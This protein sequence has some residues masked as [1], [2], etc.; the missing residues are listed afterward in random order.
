MGKVLGTDSTRN[1]ELEANQR[2]DFKLGMGDGIDYK[3]IDMRRSPL[4]TLDHMIEQKL[5]EAAPEGYIWMGKTDINDDGKEV[6]KF[7]KIPSAQDDIKARTSTALDGLLTELE[8]VNGSPIDKPKLKRLMLSLHPHIRE[9]LYEGLTEVIDNAYGA[10]LAQQYKDV[11]KEQ[12]EK[13]KIAPKYTKL[14]ST[15]RLQTALA[16]QFV[17]STA[18]QTL[19]IPLGFV[20]DL[21]KEI[22][23]SYGAKGQWDF[24]TQFTV[25]LMT[26]IS[27]ILKVPDKVVTEQLHTEVK[28]LT[29]AGFQF[30]KST[31]GTLNKILKDAKSKLN[32]KHENI[33]NPEEKV[34]NAA[35]AAQN[36]EYE[37]AMVNNRSLTGDSKDHKVFEG[38]PTQQQGPSLGG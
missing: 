6:Q 30:D 17:V 2:E 36:A 28:K 9:E 20:K 11:T 10:E 38:Q 35:E 29:E 19:D 1:T 4:E 32:V 34:I 14:P 13:A 21:V 33:K 7:E 22:C 8:K 31:L 25:S 16:G 3:P 12:A 5:I 23:G 24:F 18:R 37:A 27:D 26:Y 15:A